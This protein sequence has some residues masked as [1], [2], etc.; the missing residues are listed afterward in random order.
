MGYYSGK[1]MGQIATSS[2]Q[3]EVDN[4]ISELT[5]PLSSTQIGKLNTFVN[6]IKTGM[7]LTNLADA[8]DVMY[9]L[10]GETQESSLRNLVKRQHDC[11]N[12]NLPYY[13]QYE[14]FGSID[15]NKFIDTNYN[16]VNTLGNLQQNSSSMGFYSR[17]V[18][19]GGTTIEMGF[20]GFIVTGKPPGLS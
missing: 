12:S 20:S 14:G 9:I 1:L 3:V 8:F 10:A 7:G 13:V 2:N 11:T 6:S 17:T 4:Y 18:G 19:G 5:T 15:N 16:P